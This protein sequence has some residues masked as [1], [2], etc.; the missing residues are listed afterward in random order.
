MLD[1]E[2]NNNNMSLL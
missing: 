1:Y 2:Q